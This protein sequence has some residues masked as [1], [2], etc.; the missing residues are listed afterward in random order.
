MWLLSCTKRLEPRKVHSKR[1]QPPGETCDKATPFRSGR[2]ALQAL[3]FRLFQ[4]PLVTQGGCFFQ[5][6][7]TAW[8]RYLTNVSPGFPQT[9]ANQATNQPT[10]QPTN[11]SGIARGHYQ[12]KCFIKT[13][14][15]SDS[16]RAAGKAVWLQTV[17]GWQ[18][19]LC[20]EEVE[21]EVAV[22]VAVI[23]IIVVVVLV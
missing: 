6:V 15:S 8:R 11:C 16:L 17:S 5:D 18:R 23:V 14:K 22:V 7:H 13:G 21:V 4:T 2:N 10:H 20:L 1:A 19:G 3:G 9:S 12:W